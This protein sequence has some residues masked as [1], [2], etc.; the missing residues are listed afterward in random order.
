MLCV[1]KTFKCR[2]QVQ[3]SKH[4]PLECTH[5]LSIVLEHPP[6]GVQLIRAGANIFLVKSIAQLHASL[7]ATPRASTAMG[8]AHQQLQGP[9]LGP[10]IKQPLMHKG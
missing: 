2:L 5:Y 4:P 9:H 3:T 6:K 7:S 10:A 8:A 1:K